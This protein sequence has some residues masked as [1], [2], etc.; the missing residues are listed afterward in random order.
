[1]SCK[2]CLGIGCV[3]CRLSRGAKVDTF[4]QWREI[5]I[6]ENVNLNDFSLPKEGDDWEE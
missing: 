3:D 6:E 4:E 5:M 1:M 2:T